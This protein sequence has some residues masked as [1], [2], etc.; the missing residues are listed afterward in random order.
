MHH[1]E[2]TPPFIRRHIVFLSIFALALGAASGFLGAAYTHGEHVIA[3]STAVSEAVSRA[4]KE[5]QVRYESALKTA[6]TTE[7]KATSIAPDYAT[8]CKPVSDPESITVIVNK[9]YCFEPLNWTPTDLTYIEDK[10]QL[11]KE[12]AR[13]YQ[14]ML[15][16]ATSDNASFA[17]SSAYRSYSDQ[18]STYEHW[19]STN[20]STQTADLVSARAGYSEHQT[21]LAV[22]LKSGNCVLECFATTAAY[23]W[24]TAHAADYG[25]IQRYQE[26]T[27]S[28]TGYATESWHWRY[29]GVS[30]AKT[31]KRLGL[32][33]LETYLQFTAR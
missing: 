8:S 30:T 21:G 18:I 33:T 3:Q 20:G 22:D 28:I 17:A 1:P 4:T 31:M 14:A 26:G 23:K 24:L 32:K 10:Y 27:T 5:A 11:R 25:F 7:T 16:A 29:V 12:A 19:V 9:T 15:T 13:S 2:P 6:Q